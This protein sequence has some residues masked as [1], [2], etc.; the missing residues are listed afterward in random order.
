MIQDEVLN[1][2]Y[3][4]EFIKFFNNSSD[5]NYL[6]SLVSHPGMNPACLFENLVHH[7]H[8]F[9]LPRNMN[10]MSFLTC[11]ISASVL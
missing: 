4:Y 6:F 3:I 5:I 7:I 9:N 8:C 11:G 10:N 2:R 1:H